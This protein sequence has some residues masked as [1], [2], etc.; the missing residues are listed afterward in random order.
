M[1]PEIDRDRTQATGCSGKHLDVLRPPGIGLDECDAR[2][3]NLGAYGRAAGF[4]N[5]G[6]A[7]RREIKRSEVIKHAYQVK[8]RGVAEFELSQI[9]AEPIPQP[10]RPENALELPHHDGRFLVDDRAVKA[11][12]FIEICQFLSNRVRARSAIHC[13]S[14]RIVSNEKPELVIHLGKSRIHDFRSHEVGEDLF[15]P[16]VVEPAH[17]NEVAEPHMRCLVRDRARAIQHLVL[18]CR[19]IEENRRRV[20]EDRARMFHPTELKRRNGDE[21]ELAEWIRNRSVL[22]E[23]LQR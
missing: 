21:V 17:G 23:P 10:V 13:I 20:V 7:P 12:G 19:L 15:H 1:I 22:F 11:T 5:P 14:C 8:P 6:A 4:L 2:S 18:G 16:D 9:G 3:F